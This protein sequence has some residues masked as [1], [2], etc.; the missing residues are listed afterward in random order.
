MP[1]EIPANRTSRDEVVRFLAKRQLD[2]SIADRMD[3]LHLHANVDVMTAVYL[4][5]EELGSDVGK[6][7]RS[8]PGLFVFNTDTLDAKQAFLADE[9]GLRRTA[10]A[11][12]PE[13]FT[14][15]VES[16]RETCGH[17][18]GRFDGDR[19]QA[20][21]LLRTAP[22]LFGYDTGVVDHKMDEFGG[23][24]IDFRRNPVLLELK[25]GKVID[26]RDY[27]TE[28]GVEV[29]E[30]GKW[31]HMLLAVS[32]EKLRPKVEYCNQEGIRWKSYPKVLILGIG[33]ED[34][35]GELRKKVDMIK[36]ASRNG[37]LPERLDYMSRPEVLCNSTMSSLTSSCRANPATEYRW[38]GY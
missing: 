14:Y 37:K 28:L 35:P 21:A 25:P 7:F 31:Y 33:T 8:Y 22:A 29:P 27:L 10:M 20:K 34:K 30:V 16:M 6:T 3:V 9:I 15:S 2:P 4:F 5:F 12:L 32:R 1:Q 38:R 17:Y 18:A 19:E 24:G 11:R 36:R 26:T 13:L 23:A